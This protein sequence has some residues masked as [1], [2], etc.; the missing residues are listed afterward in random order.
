[1]EKSERFVVSEDRV[2]A[3]LA[4]VEELYPKA[5]LATVRKALN[6]SLPG[7]AAS[8]EL[9]TAEDILLYQERLDRAEPSELGAIATGII[10]DFAGISPVEAIPLGTLLDEVDQILKGER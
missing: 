10:D 5:T 1:V 8:F 6:G 4:Y 9:A 7:M 2:L 3:A